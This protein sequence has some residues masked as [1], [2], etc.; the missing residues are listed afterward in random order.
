MLVHQLGAQIVTQIIKKDQHH[1]CASRGFSSLRPRLVCKHAKNCNE[2]GLVNKDVKIAN[3][4][5]VYLN[6]EVNF[7]EQAKLFNELNEFACP[8]NPCG[9]RLVVS[10]FL[11]IFGGL[12][13]V[14]SCDQLL[15]QCANFFAL[16][17][18]AW[19]FTIVIRHF[20][21]GTCVR[22]RPNYVGMSLRTGVVNS[23]VTVA[24]HG[25]C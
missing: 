8:L 7:N 25:G 14:R 13:G 20:K 3:R 1:I 19:R 11:P 4:S 23:G 21:L 2:W 16:S 9:T 22:E 18:H 12:A 15:E 6:F 17:H 10:I 24:A 5:N